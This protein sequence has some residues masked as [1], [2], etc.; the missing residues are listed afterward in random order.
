[1]TNID[2]GKSLLS[3]SECTVMRGFAIVAIVLNNFGT[4]IKGVVPDNEFIYDYS[5]LEAFVNS[6]IHPGKTIF[7]DLL[8]FYSPFGVM[9]FVFLSGYGLTLKYEM[10]NV[11]PLKK[12]ITEHYSKLFFMQLKGIALFLT[13]VLIYDTERVVYLRHLL[14]QIFMIENLNPINPKI[15]AGPYWFFCMIMEI[16]II[17]R[18]F[19]YRKSLWVL[20]FVISFSL[21]VM[22]CVQPNGELIYYLRY[23]FL[24]ALLPFGLGILTARYGFRFSSTLETTKKC[25]MTFV[26]GL[27]LLTLCKFNFYSWLIMPLFIIWVSIPLTKLLSKFG[28]VRNIFLWLGSLSGVI[29]IVHPIFREILI[30]RTNLYGNY[31]GMLFV[32]L[33]LTISLSMIMKPFFLS[34]S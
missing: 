18:Y 27:I 25:V 16:Y 32:Y 14:G 28:L 22:A 1:M 33:F 17:Y 6:M 12:F 2:N 15:I 20:T 8:A 4:W 13:I 23:N 3:R 11:V 10:G 29:F 7:L 21:V 34:K 24:M 9:L 30:E 26:V 31:Y 19:L 5:R